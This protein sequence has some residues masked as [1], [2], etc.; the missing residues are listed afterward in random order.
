MHSIR[1]WV[2]CISRL[3]VLC[4][5]F[6]PKLFD[7]KLNRSLIFGISVSTTRNFV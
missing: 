6:E 2:I 5:L 7:A 4:R 3:C 1:F